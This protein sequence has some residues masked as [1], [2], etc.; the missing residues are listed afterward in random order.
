MKRG[1]SCLPTSRLVAKLNPMKEHIKIDG[2]LSKFKKELGIK[3]DIELTES[4][5]I[6]PEILLTWEKEENIDCK[7][8]I[9]KCLSNG[10]RLNKVFDG[11]EKNI[12]GTTLEIFIE[13]G[14]AETSID[15]IAQ[16]AG[17]SKEAVHEYYNSKNQG[18]A[19]TQ[20]GF[21]SLSVKAGFPRKTNYK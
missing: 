3:N 4:L 20:G 8:L 12:I 19:S 2:A 6:S 14:H 7:L 16:K 10:I 11:Q 17:L 21:Y 1:E 9:N 5:E 18:P 15:Y 13:K